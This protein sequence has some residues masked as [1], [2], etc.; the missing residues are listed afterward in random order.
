[1]VT[2]EDA[3]RLAGGRHRRRSSPCG[4]SRTTSARTRRR[5][6]LAESD[7][8]ARMRASIGRSPAA[9]NLFAETAGVLRRRRGRHRRAS[10]RSTRRSPSRRLPALQAG[11]RGRDDRHRQDHPLR[12]AGSDASTR[13][14]AARGAGE[15]AVR[16][17]PYRA[18]PGRRRLDGAAGPQAVGRQEDAARCLRERLAP[19]GRAI[20]AE[21]AR[22]ARD[23]S[24]RRRSFARLGA[25]EA[26]LIVVFGASAIADRRDVIPAAHRGGGRPG[27][28]FR[29]AGRSRQ[30]AAHRRARRQAGD[31]RAGLRALARRR[32]ASTGCCSACSPACR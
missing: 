20:V 3:A 32:T 27:R 8:R 22:A 5:A 9:A 25:D 18:A 19:A 24:A 23:G 7:R 16:V 31:R 1:M 13:A 6:R 2:A 15:G 30:P 11:R 21:V 29:H 14:L 4:S 26:D 10:T 17:A 12:G 28:A